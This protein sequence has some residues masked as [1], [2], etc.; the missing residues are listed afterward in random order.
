[1]IRFECKCGKKIKVDDKLA[2]KRGKC[3]QCQ[4]IITIPNPE[5]ANSIDDLMA[6]FAKEPLSQAVSSRFSNTDSFQEVNQNPANTINNAIEKQGDKKRC[7]ACNKENVATVNKCEHCGVGT[8][9]IKPKQSGFTYSLLCVLRGFIIFISLGLTI[10]FM[11]G[12]CL[13]FISF[14]RQDRT[15]TPSVSYKS[16]SEKIEDDKIPACIKIEQY[17]ESQLVSPGSA[18]FPFAH[19]MLIEYE[20]NGIYS[21]YSHVDSQNLMGGLLRKRFFCKIRKVGTEWQIM[22]FEWKS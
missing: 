13:I 21:L 22:S 7:P 5:P 16:E 12:L 1:M 3:P 4:E 14:V 17:V 18:E 6:D 20:G 8:T 11:V 19:S 10:T 9:G 2:G 15:T